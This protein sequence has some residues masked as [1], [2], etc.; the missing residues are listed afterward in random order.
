MINNEQI[1]T[2]QRSQK[3]CSSLSQNI[4]INLKKTTEQDFPFF[5]R[6]LDEKENNKW[7]T[8]FYRLVKYNEI[9]HSLTIKKKENCIFTIFDDEKPIGFIGLYNI[10]PLDKSAMIWD[11]LGDKTYARKG[12]MTTAMHLCIQQA[13][14]TLGLHSISGWLVEDNI[15]ALRVAEKN[16]FKRIGVQRECHFIDGVFKNR[17]LV[18]LTI[19][20]IK[21]D[22]EKQ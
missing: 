21:E 11:A 17:I 3:I 13:F 18:D 9:I 12:V 5:Q 6:W 22:L 4:K 8:S 2:E 14:S 10:D 20:D 1:G 16:N 19:N 15:P 7:Y